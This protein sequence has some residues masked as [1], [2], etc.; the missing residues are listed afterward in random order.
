VKCGERSGAVAECSA[1]CRI[2]ASAAAACGLRNDGEC[3]SAESQPGA[4]RARTDPMNRSDDPLNRRFRRGDSCLETRRCSA[5]PLQNA[6]RRGEFRLRRISPDA[7]MSK[8]G[9]RIPIHSTA[10]P[11]SALAA[12]IY[13]SANPLRYLTK[14]RLQLCHEDQSRNASAI[15][16]K[17]SPTLFRESVS[18]LRGKHG[19]GFRQKYPQKLCAFYFRHFSRNGTRLV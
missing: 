6:G 16:R 4:M 10:F 18:R 13:A 9:K 7:A 8:K 12:R 1:A 14:S 3:T 5:Y 11:G 19:W 17:R 15:G 2:P